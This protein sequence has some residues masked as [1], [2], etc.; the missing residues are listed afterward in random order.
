M[1]ICES[2]SRV[3]R[4]REIRSGAGAA[5][6]LEVDEGRDGAPVPGAMRHQ[7]EMGRAPVLDQCR[8]CVPADA[9]IELFQ[10]A[11]AVPA[12]AD[13]LAF[14]PLFGVDL[15]DALRADAAAVGTLEPGKDPGPAAEVTGQAPAAAFQDVGEAGRRAAERTDA[16]VPYAVAEVRAA[17]GEVV[18]QDRAQTAAGEKAEGFG[19]EREA[20]TRPAAPGHQNLAVR[21]QRLTKRR[22]PLEQG[23]PFLQK[24][25]VGHWPVHR[26]P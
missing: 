13:Q 19:R 7:V 25:G 22:T 21:L 14:S 4:A 16:E 24:R 23:L 12:R 2:R 1:R 17:P 26:P 3:C 9:S 18:F 20:L 10:V 11:V 15:D 8:P 6:P 5:P